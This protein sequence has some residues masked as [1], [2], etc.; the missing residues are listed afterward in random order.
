MNFS[1]TAED[2]NIGFVVVYDRINLFAIAIRPLFF[3]CGHHEDAGHDIVDMAARIKRKLLLVIL[4]VEY[5]YPFILG[6]AVQFKIRVINLLQAIHHSHC[7]LM[8]F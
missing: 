3:F 6:D 2:D 7:N 5:Y 8:L 4:S 1:P